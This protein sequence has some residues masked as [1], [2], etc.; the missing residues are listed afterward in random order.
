MIVDMNLMMKILYM[1]N[2]TNNIIINMK[3]IWKIPK[4][5]ENLRKKK[6]KE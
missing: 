4:K 2:K 6:K 1:I 5:L 3:K